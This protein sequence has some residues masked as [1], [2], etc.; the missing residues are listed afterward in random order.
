MGD[1]FVVALF[2]SFAAML[3]YLIF[4]LI[5]RRQQMS[6]QKHLLDKFSSAHDFSEFV[7]SP[8]GQ[9]YVAGFSDRVADSHASI[10]ASVRIGIVVLFLG[11]AFFLVRTF[12]RDAYYLLHGLGTVL[13]MLG[14][15]FVASSIVS[16]QIAKRIRA[17]RVN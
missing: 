14:A 13:S 11:L 10:L 7:Q 12:D 1:V 5:R 15:G 4:G 9:K 16:Y 2:F 3:V 6:M 8:A 17:E